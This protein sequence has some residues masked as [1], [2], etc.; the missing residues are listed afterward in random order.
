MILNVYEFL[1]R[2]V[3]KKVLNYQNKIKK[4]LLQIKNKIIIQTFLLL[5]F[6]AQ[7]WLPHPPTH[8]AYLRGCLDLQFPSL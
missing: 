2:T 6:A 1:F 3:L 8:F 4:Y 5:V 7:H